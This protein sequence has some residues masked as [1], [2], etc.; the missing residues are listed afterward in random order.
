LIGRSQLS[1]Q[2]SQVA[3]GRVSGTMPTVDLYILLL[4]LH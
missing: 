3:C 2:T 4:E 1:L